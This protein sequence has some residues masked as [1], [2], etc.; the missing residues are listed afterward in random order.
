VLTAKGQ[1]TRDRIVLAASELMVENGVAGTTMERVREA[2]GV[3]F[4]QLYHYFDDKMALVHAVIALQTRI[5]VDEGQPRLDSMRALR[6]W[7]DG[8][9]AMQRE[10]ECRG[11]CALRSLSSELSE[12]SIDA[13]TELSRSF[14]RWEAAIREGLDAMQARGELRPEVDTERLAVATLA[15]VQGGLVLAQ[16]QRNTR[17]LELA[18]DMALAHIQA[19]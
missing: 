15:A 12:L 17:P 7:R 8:L 11:G 16:A 19:S 9:V 10:R 5:I 14:T 2:A 4:S 13:R 1:A 3:S 18:L 6:R